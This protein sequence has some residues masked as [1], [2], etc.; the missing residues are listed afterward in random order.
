MLFILPKVR[1]GR[2]EE[3]GKEYYFQV[4][5]ERGNGDYEI[6]LIENGFHVSSVTLPRS[7]KENVRFTTSGNTYKLIKPAMVLGD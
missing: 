4:M 1:K 7:L 5:S 3:N 6:H 2:I